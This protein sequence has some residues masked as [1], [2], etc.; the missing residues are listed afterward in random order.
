MNGLTS[1]PRRYIALS[2]ITGPKLIALCRDGGSQ[3]LDTINLL[4]WSPLL[5]GVLHARLQAREV[6]GIIELESGDIW[7]LL[8]YPPGGKD[9]TLC[10][11]Q[12]SELFANP[13]PMH[14]RQVFHIRAAIPDVYR[15]NLRYIYASACR[16]PD[17]H[18]VQ[19]IWVHTRKGEFAFFEGG[20][21]QWSK[22]LPGRVSKT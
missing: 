21:L 22:S 19:H 15:S 5:P 14:E 6:L 1:T 2:V 7:Q 16:A 9:F 20:R 3:N 17:F 4:E 12:R 18:S 10:S 13:S 11:A 8:Y